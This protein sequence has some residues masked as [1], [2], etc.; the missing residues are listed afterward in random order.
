MYLIFLVKEVGKCFGIWRNNARSR[1]S[2]SI[3]NHR[4]LTEIMSNFTVPA[5]GLTTLV[6]RT[7]TGAT[8][9]AS[10]YL[11]VLRSTGTL[12]MIIKA[13]CLILSNPR[14]LPKTYFL[15]DKDCDRTDVAKKTMSCNRQRWE[16]SV[17]KIGVYLVS[18]TYSIIWP[19]YTPL[20]LAIHFLSPWDNIKWIY[21]KCVWIT[22]LR[23]S[24]PTV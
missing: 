18:R 2:H 3:N 17:I 24:Y 16:V 23:Y 1:K 9:F 6:A 19:T 4:Y 20:D 8:N 21:S 12:Q 15:S 14:S 10:V 5:D 11:N 7:T 13:I 22:R